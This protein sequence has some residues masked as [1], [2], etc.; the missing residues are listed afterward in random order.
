MSGRLSDKKA[1]F[2]DTLVGNIS[3]L[4]DLLP[5]LNVT[6]DEELTKMCDEVR[7]KLTGFTPKE[8]RKDTTAREDTARAA[9]A[10]MDKM[11]GYMS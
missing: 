1:V 6:G 3:E 8:L 4:C 7:D 9:A 11:A 5:S 2:R 10:I